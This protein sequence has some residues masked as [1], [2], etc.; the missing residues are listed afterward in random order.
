MEGML[1]FFEDITTTTC[2]IW[3]YSTGSKY[4]FDSNDGC[5]RQSCHGS[6]I[7]YVAQRA[8]HEKPTRRTQRAAEFECPSAP[9]SQSSALSIRWY[10]RGNTRISGIFGASSFYVHTSRANG[11]SD[12]DQVGN[13]TRSP[14]DRFC[15]Y[16]RQSTLHNRLARRHAKPSFP[17]DMDQMVPWL[18]FDLTRCRMRLFGMDGR[19]RVTQS[20]ESTE[21]VKE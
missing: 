6:E 16:V 2:G 20:S 1:T 3:N 8:W 18:G 13:S 7:F 9:W 4:L 15:P 12:C 11:I 14:L 19:R 21:Y 5:L 17:H 10:R